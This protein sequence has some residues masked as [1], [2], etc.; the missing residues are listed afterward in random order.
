MPS[1][2]RYEKVTCGNCG[3]QTTKPNLARHE[4]RCSAG[5]L[6]CSQCPNF[7]TKSQIDLNYHIAKKHCAPKRDITFRCKLRYAEIPGYY[8]LP[9]HKNTQHG[10]QMGCGASNFDVE[11][12]VGD[13]DNQSLREELESCQHILTDTEMKNGSTESSTLPCRPSTCFCSTINWIMYSRN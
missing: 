3:T 7:F 9:Q 8:A 11:D 5:T 6:Y 13:V 1:L 4:K 2:N 10:P 12:L